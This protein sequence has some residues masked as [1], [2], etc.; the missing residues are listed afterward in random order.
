M[1]RDAVLALA[2]GDTVKA[3]VT[4]MPISSGIV[5][6]FVAGETVADV[7]ATAGVLADIG[8]YATIDFLGEDSTDT[9]Q[10]E[11]T[12]D[13]Y[14]ELLA[15]LHA[16]SP[17]GHALSATAEV[18]IKLSALGQGL[19]SDGD[20][21]ALDNARA[22]AAAAT[23]AGTTVTVDAED[24]T[25]TD[26]TLGIVAALRED[27]P[28]T[29]AVVQAGLRRT[30]QDCRALAVAGSRVRLCKGAYRESEHVAFMNKSD[31]DRSYVRCMKI[32][33]AGEGFP[34]LAT[35]DPRLIEI[36]AAVAA[37]YGRASGSFEYQMLHGVRPDEQKRLAARG[38][39]VRVYVPFGDQWY[40]Y[41]MRRMAE[42]PANAAVFLRSLVTKK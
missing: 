30:E 37:R 39:T 33:L 40:G 32:L 22:I 34:M 20:A 41:L 21:L 31:I 3:L 12:R 1:L 35:H 8:L 2:A 9:A 14:L 6:R 24:H 23:E 10:A 27:Y 42:K 29:G 26:S 7:V 16:T 25:T 17:A 11:K 18:S 28:M 5:R 19:G 36:A 15:A 13:A 4:G 38:E